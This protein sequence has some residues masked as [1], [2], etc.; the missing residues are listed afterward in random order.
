MATI[1]QLAQ[2]LQE[3]RQQ[4]DAERA[5]R[6]AAEQGRPGSPRR[7][8]DGGREQHIDPR[9]LNKCPAFSGYDKHLQELSFIFESA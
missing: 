4:L 5:Q 8:D 7:R 2:A 1:E 9:V 3:M 6:V